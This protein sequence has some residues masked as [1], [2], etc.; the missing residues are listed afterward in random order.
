M[1][2]VAPGSDLLFCCG[3]SSAIE[4]KRG[5]PP[6]LNPSKKPSHHRQHEKKS[7]V[8]VAA[9]STSSPRT[10][11]DMEVQYIMLSFVGMSQLT[12]AKIMR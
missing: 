3:T 7:K 9:V 2:S 1:P 8:A 6:V 5:R 11:D 10:D 4:P 12:V